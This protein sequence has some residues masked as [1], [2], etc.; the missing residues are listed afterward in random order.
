MGF[1]TLDR[2][3]ELV[4]WIQPVCYAY[5]T[6]PKWCVCVFT[7]FGTLDKELELVLWIQHVVYAYMTSPKWCVCV[8]M[9]FGTLDKE[10]ELVLWIQHVCYTYMT[11]PKWC[12]CSWTAWAGVPSTE[13][14]FPVHFWLLQE[15][16][17][18]SSHVFSLPSTTSYLILPACALN[19]GLL[20]YWTCINIT[21]CILF[22]WTVRMLLVHIYIL[23]SLVCLRS[24]C[25]L[26]ILNLILVCDWRPVSL[27]RAMVVSVI[28]VGL[29]LYLPLC[30]WALLSDFFWLC[31]CVWQEQEL[32]SSSSFFHS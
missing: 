24:C 17:C 32:L 15:I 16:I 12:A 25:H 21:A 4:L 26:S 10:L 23:W 14:L 19:V 11:S 30:L 6:S 31:A 29:Y 18:L 27:A 22:S 13:D 28:L 3:L 2:R 1:G 9:D 8:F 20:V 5:M 7:D